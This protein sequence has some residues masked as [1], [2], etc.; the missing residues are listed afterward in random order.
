[1]LGGLAWLIATAA[2]AAT[3]EKAPPLIPVEDFARS[4]DLTAA[5]LAPDGKFMGYLFTHEGR[6]EMGFLDLAT[7]KARYFNHGRSVF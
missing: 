1:M 4:P 6:T 5:Q 7:G 3:G 2:W